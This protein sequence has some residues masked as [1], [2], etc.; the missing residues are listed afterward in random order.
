[1]ILISCSAELFIPVRISGEFALRICARYIEIMKRL[2]SRRGFW[3]CLQRGL[4]AV[5][6]VFL[7]SP[8]FVRADQVHMQNGDNYYG[9]IVSLDGDTLV[10]QSDVLGTIQV[11]RAKIA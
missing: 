11:P 10:L 7:L 2:I 1:M 3:F 4:I 6:L 8:C 9:K 5:S